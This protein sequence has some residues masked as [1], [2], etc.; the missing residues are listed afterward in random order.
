MGSKPA[1]RFAG[2]AGLTL[3]ELLVA[4]SIL[5]VVAVLG[6]RG[7]D[8]I[9][10]SRSKLAGEMEQVRAR[11][12]TFAQLQ[13]D[14]EQL[15]THANLTGREVLATGSGQLVLVRN[16]VA[17]SQ[18]LHLQVVAYRLTDGALMRSE[19]AAT[20]DLRELDAYWRAA[21]ADEASGA[22]ALQTG[23]SEMAMRYWPGGASGWRTPP[24]G[25]A[26]FVAASKT[27]PSGL[28]ITLQAEGRAATVKAM[29]LGVK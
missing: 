28:E 6:W 18:P 29:L 23:L 25:G 20:R 15:A 7:L 19:S 8:T 27:M 4:I 12:L 5:A 3:V 16:V 1:C 10:R 9:L 13:R 14:C 17:D 22:I 11:Q 2:A 26:T 24:S 21:V